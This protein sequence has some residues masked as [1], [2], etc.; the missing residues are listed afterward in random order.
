MVESSTTV[1]KSWIDRIERGGGEADIGI[2]A[3]MRSFSGDLISRA[4]FGSNYSKGEEIF[5]KL[6]ALQEALSKKM[7]APGIPGLRY[8]F[9]VCVCVIFLH[10]RAIDI[11]DLLI[12]VIGNVSGTSPRRATGQYGG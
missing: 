7:L 3:D 8:Q 5:I 9:C 10:A 1:V 12:S 11:D 2:D 4:C 6:R